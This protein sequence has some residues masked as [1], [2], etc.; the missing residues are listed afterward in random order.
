MPRGDNIHIKYPVLFSVNVLHHYFLDSKEKA[1]D[2][3]ENGEK[4]RALARYDVRKVLEIEPTRPTSDLLRGLGLIFKKHQLGFVV[5]APADSAGVLDATKKPDANTILQ[6]TVKVVDPYF[7]QYSA[8]FLQ[9]ENVRIEKATQPGEQD[10][11]FK[12]VF[13]LKNFD[14]P[15][16]PFLAK[17]P[18][19]YDGNSEYLPES[20]VK[21]QVNGQDVFFMAKQFVPANTAPQNAS[22][23][24]WL[25][26]EQTQPGNTNIHYVTASS[27][28]EVELGAEIPPDTFALIE[29]QGGNTQGAFSLYDGGGN[30]LSPKL[31]IR[32]KNRLTWWRHSLSPGIAGPTTVIT[33]QDVLP[34]TAQGKKKL[35]LT[36]QVNTGQGGTQN[37]ERKDVEN[38]GG[39]TAILPEKLVD[40]R[41]KRLLS[42]IYL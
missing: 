29:V 42:E 19:D 41:L 8:A 3:L 21:G 5:L 24:N 7:F 39:S 32:F 30:L 22:D 35:D 9:V 15:Q 36:F 26:L 25:K 34:L 4:L 38:P 40:G 11:F 10:R 1:F 20:F 17:A 14:S 28:E 18:E 12:K 27:L 2:N 6:F 16:S 33:Q 37:L 13:R 31:E 23:S